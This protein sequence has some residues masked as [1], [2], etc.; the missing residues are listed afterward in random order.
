MPKHLTPNSVS[1]IKTRIWNGELMEL[2]AES[3]GRSEAL[4]GN[5]S[6]GHKWGT[7]PWPDGSIGPLPQSQRAIINNARKEARGI[8]NKA[9]VALVK[10]AAKQRG[11]T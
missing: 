4:I 10:K 11:K 5:I 7:V 9:T 3:V 1:H 6:S 2:I 8:Y